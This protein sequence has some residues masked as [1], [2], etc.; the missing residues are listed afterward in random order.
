MFHLLMVIM[1]LSIILHALF[2]IGE[3]N[4][5]FLKIFAKNRW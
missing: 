5:V 4:A 3:K 2:L 1:S